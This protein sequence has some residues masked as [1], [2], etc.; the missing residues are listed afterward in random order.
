MVWAAVGISAV[1]VGSSLIGGASAKK[2][3]EAAAKAQAKLT[4]AQRQEEI[5]MKKRSAAH[6][7]G[8][9]VATVA[10]S[11]LQMSGSSAR[12]VNAMDTENMRE[13]AFAKNAAALEKRAIEKGAAGAGAGLFANAGAQLG[14]LAGT[15]AG[16]YLAPAAATSI[17]TSTA[18]GFTA[19]GNAGQLSYSSTPL[20]QTA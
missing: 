1:S 11:N 10:A 3:A 15:L 2:K 6:D 20:G 12:F 4:F 5:R 13:I 7:K 9:G 19:A 18:G 17:D 8:L 14:Q 16:H